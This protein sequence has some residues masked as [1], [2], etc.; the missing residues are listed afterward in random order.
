MIDSDHVYFGEKAES[1]TLQRGSLQVKNGV[2]CDPHPCAHPY[3]HKIKDH[4]WFRDAPNF[5]GR[6]GK[7]T[8]NMSWIYMPLRPAPRYSTVWTF[9]STEDFVTCQ[10]LSAYILHNQQVQWPCIVLVLFTLMKHMERTSAVRSYFQLGIVRLQVC[11]FLPGYKNRTW[12]YWLAKVAYST[13]FILGDDWLAELPPPPS[14]LSLTESYT[15]YNS[16]SE[17]LNC[18]LP[19]CANIT[20][21]AHY[22]EQRDT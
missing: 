5:A 4:K 15:V 20:F 14:S 7:K 11:S 12:G 13:R 3:I 16:C 1:G 18:S 17:N 22:R 2:P 9:H 6:K 10:N 21:T 8:K 19:N